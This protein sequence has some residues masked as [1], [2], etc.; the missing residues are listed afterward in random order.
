MSEIDYNICNSSKCEYYNECNCQADVNQKEKCLIKNAIDFKKWISEM[1]GIELYICPII[2]RLC[3]KDS[4]NIFHINSDILMKAIEC[5]NI[6]SSNVDG[7]RR[8][9]EMGR[10]MWNVTTWEKEQKTISFTWDDYDGMFGSLKQAIKFI[11][12]K[13][14]KSNTFKENF[15]KAMNNPKQ[16]EFSEWDKNN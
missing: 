12:I 14:R 15:V 3:F 1:I 13:E 4:G 6:S 9:I 11:Y 2:H 8:Y 5:I 7:K 10:Y 16:K